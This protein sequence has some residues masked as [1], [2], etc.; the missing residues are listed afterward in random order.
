MDSI[1]CY[2]I[3]K[4][5][6]TEKLEII[7]KHFNADCIFYRGPIVDNTLHF[8]RIVEEI[9]KEKAHTSLVFILTTTGGSIQAV[10]RMVNILRHHYGKVI[11]IIPDYAYSAGT[12]LCM[13]GDEIYMDYRGALGPIDPQVQ[14]KDGEWVSALGYLD[15]INEI[16]KKSENNTITQVEFAMLANQDLGMVRQYEQ[17]K[18]YS[19]ELL[20]KYLVE[21]KFKNWKIREASKIAV[22]DE[23][24]TSRALYIAEQLGSNSWYSH[25]RPINITTLLEM[26][27]KIKDYSNDD[28]FLNMLYD[29]YYPMVEHAQNTDIFIHTRRYF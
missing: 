14:T 18:S 20:K 26:G 17:V 10:E 16:L 21:Y 4:R 6:L 9:A 3:T 25:G 8:S 13:S 11:F 5:A 15:K 22:D 19:I 28:V 7:E 23:Y 29:Y 27:L 24:K 2:D 1:T 12:I